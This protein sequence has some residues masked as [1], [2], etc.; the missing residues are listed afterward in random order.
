MV[1]NEAGDANLRSELRRTY[2]DGPKVSLPRT[3]ARW[4]SAT[5]AVS[6]LG[7]GASGARALVREANTTPWID[8]V[9]VLEAIIERYAD[10]ANYVLVFDELDEDYGSAGLQTDEYWQLLASLF[11]AVQDVRATFNSPHYNLR[12]IVFLRDDIYER[13]RDPDKTKWEDL[14]YRLEW[15]P[16]MIKDL[17]AFRISRA[18]SS[19][20]VL[21][22]DRRGMSFSKGLRSALE[23]IKARRCHPSNS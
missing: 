5:F 4:T 22:F 2:E 6:V 13:I 10:S 3:I 15:T 9:E 21:P 8:R 11:K 16:P 18:S 7:T 14:I 12:P 1:D 19:A 17:L 20:E 23:T